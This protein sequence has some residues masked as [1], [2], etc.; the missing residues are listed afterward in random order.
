MTEDAKKDVGKCLTL[1]MYSGVINGYQ[2]IGVYLLR[3]TFILPLE[4]LSVK[5]YHK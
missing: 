1:V 4:N 2:Q 5:E 3:V